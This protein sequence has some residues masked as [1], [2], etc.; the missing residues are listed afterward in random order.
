M[1]LMHLNIKE[2]YAL[3]NFKKLDIYH[4]AKNKIEFLKDLKSYLLSKYI[5]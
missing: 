5:I 1:V 2:S 4:N 3:N